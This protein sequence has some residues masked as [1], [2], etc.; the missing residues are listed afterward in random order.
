MTTS[1]T[2][3][4]QGSGVS[5]KKPKMPVKRRLIIVAAVLVLVLLPAIIM[6]L[7]TWAGTG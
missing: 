2:N 6:V 7:V 5:V 4:S 3:A 1:G